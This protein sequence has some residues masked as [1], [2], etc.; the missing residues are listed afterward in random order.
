MKKNYNLNLCKSLT[1]GIFVLTFAAS[2]SAQNRY[3]ATTGTDASNNCTNSATP[4]LTI[5]HAV[6]IALD[7]D[8]V[9][10]K[11]GNYTL[12]TTLGITQ[13][14]LVLTALD[15]VK[16]V[17][18]SQASDVVT[19]SAKNVTLSKLI[20]KMGLTNNSG[21]RGIVGLN[22]Y[23]SIQVVNSEFVSTKPKTFLSQ[24]FVFGAYAMLFQLPDATSYSVFINN[25]V[26][27]Q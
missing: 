13:E 15:S 2:A 19:V 10:V 16:P 17:I 18:T 21:M 1:L 14:G 5:S 6:S 26:I 24:G 4:C 22:N 9:F 27:G 7:N 3:V 23:D 12:S 8:T 11:G 20:F 25:N